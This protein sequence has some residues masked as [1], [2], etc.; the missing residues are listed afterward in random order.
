[1]QHHFDFSEYPKEHA[2][3][4]AD[5]QAVIGKFKDETSG[6]PIREFVGLKPKMYG[7]I[8]EGNESQT[9]AKGIS[10]SVKLEYMQYKK[11]LFKQ[12]TTKVT[13]HAIRSYKHQL[14]T[15]EQTKLGLS[16][17]DTKRHI[18]DCGVNTLAY[19]HYKLTENLAR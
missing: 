8:Q 5:N 16:P 6:V 3:Y 14:Y 2:L 11:A 9:K 18:L 10:K 15:V 4:S 17:V 1:M 19:G 12:E 13:Q 7:F